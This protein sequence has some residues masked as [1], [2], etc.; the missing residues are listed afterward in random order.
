MLLKILF[1]ALTDVQ[2]ECQMQS[3]KSRQE[4]RSIR[5]PGPSA[6]GGLRARRSIAFGKGVVDCGCSPA[7][8][9]LG[10]CLPRK[11]KENKSY[12]WL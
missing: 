5:L 7:W 3:S 1:C 2:T 9:R 12:P 8:K 10:L 4:R 6:V 11:Q